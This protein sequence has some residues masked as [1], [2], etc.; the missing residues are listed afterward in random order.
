MNPF[1]TGTGLLLSKIGAP[2]I[3]MR[4]KGLWPLIE[5]KRRFAKPGEISLV[6]GEPVRYTSDQEAEQIA[7][8]LEERVS[9]LEHTNK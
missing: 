9:A 1:K 4:I 7:R 2:V 6:I 3:P 8:D 5:A